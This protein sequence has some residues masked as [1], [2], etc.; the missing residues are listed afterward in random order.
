[1][2]MPVKIRFEDGSEEEIPDTWIEC[3]KVKYGLDW[4]EY[5]KMIYPRIEE[6]W[7]QG[8]VLT[9]FG[10]E[11]IKGEMTR[12]EHAAMCIYADLRACIFS[13]VLEKAAQRL[14][15]EAPK[16]VG[17]SEDGVTVYK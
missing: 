15:K 16:V 1:M 12:A 17:V 11:D 6:L 9:K 13:K 4:D 2:K 10:V 3:A 5:Y 8:K 7:K 14:K